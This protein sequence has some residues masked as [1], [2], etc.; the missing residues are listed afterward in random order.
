MAV[1]IYT[2]G[3]AL[4]FSYLFDLRLK[5]PERC[6][7]FGLVRILLILPLLAGTYFYCSADMPLQLI[8]PLIFLENVFSLVW[9]LMA[10]RLQPGLDPDS[11]KPF[12]RLLILIGGILVLGTGSYGLFNPPSVDIAYDLLV[13]PRL[14]LL[15][16]SSLFMLIAAFLMAWRLEMYWRALNPQDRWRFKYLVI[17]FFLISGSYFWCAS[18]RLSYL[19]LAEN[20]FLLL[21]ILLLIGWLLVSYAVARHRLLNRKLFVSRKVVY[22]AVAPTIFAAYLILIGV[23]SIMMRAFGWSLNF[24]L[25]W[26]LVVLGIL[27]ISILALSGKVRRYVKFFISTN[28]YVNKYEYRD[29]WVA[30]SSLLQGTLTEREVVDALHRILSESLYTRQIMI[31]L[32]DVQEGFRLID[33]DKDH[34]RSADAVI[35]SDDPLVLYL[36]NEQYFYLEMRGNT[37]AR[38]LIISE[39]RDFFHQKRA[40]IDGA[41][42]HWRTVC[43]PDRLGA[44][45]HRRPL[46]P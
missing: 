44:G 29:E 24:F 9:I 17:G 40:R 19:R 10:F 18:Y 35:A 46:R 8:A 16:I 33:G 38:Q 7:S 11:P 42:D 43:G 30:F 1:I 23:F 34:S 36:K 22:S 28:F 5:E 4:I 31:W 37:Q 25:Q 45:I 2:L 20:H 3:S 6:V 12:P 13:F 32:G 15:F 26:L 39:K 41:V 21:A 14:G 27:L